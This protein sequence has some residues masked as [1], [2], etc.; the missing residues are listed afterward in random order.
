MVYSETTTTLHVPSKE[1]NHSAT[2]QI[3]A[4]KSLGISGIP[5][6]Q[7]SEELAEKERKEHAL[8]AMAIWDILRRFLPEETYAKLSVIIRNDG[9]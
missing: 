2:I 5:C 3:G 8:E 1:N 6:N 7:S 9:A 4:V